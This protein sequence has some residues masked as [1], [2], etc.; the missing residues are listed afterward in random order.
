LNDALQSSVFRKER[1]VF[2]GSSH[3]ILDHVV[4]CSEHRVD[5]S[6]A[7]QKNLKVFDRYGTEKCKD[8]SKRCG[9]AVARNI[10]K[11]TDLSTINLMYFLVQ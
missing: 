11:D 4:D 8:S 9:Q 10:R 6:F 1:A 5:V 2:E 7:A 3:P